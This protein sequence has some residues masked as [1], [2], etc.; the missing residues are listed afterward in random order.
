MNVGRWKRIYATRKARKGIQLE[1]F[2]SL[3]AA[4]RKENL[5]RLSAC[6]CVCLFGSVRCVCACS[7]TT[8][9]GRRRR[10]RRR[11]R[12]ASKRKEKADTLALAL[13]HRFFSLPSYSSPP[14][15]CTR[16]HRRI[17]VHGYCKLTDAHTVQETSKQSNATQGKT[18]YI[19]STR[20]IRHLRFQSNFSTY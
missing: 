16:T 6:V 8:L 4:G 17:H 13:S 3:Y 11:G 10:R 20:L 19:Q 12:Q 18:A 2:S 14:P 1:F 5:W 15:L 7:H 9:H